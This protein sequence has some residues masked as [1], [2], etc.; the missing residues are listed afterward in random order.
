MAPSNNSDFKKVSINIVLT[1]EANDR[2]KELARQS[3]RSKDLEAMLRL[4]DSL[5][6]VPELTGNCYDILNMK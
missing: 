2:L 3:R 1:A 4:Y 5:N 6:N